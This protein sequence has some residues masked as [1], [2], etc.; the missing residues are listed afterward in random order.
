MD[1]TEAKYDYLLPFFWELGNGKFTGDADKQLLAPIQI[2]PDLRHAAAL[3]WR[4]VFDVFSPEVVLAA[5]FRMME[6]WINS[7]LEISE[8]SDPSPNKMSVKRKLMCDYIDEFASFTGKINLTEICG[9]YLEAW[10]NVTKG[11]A[12]IANL[13]SISEYMTQSVPP[14]PLQW[15]MPIV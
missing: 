12:P 10:N 7:L 15:Y 5:V 1:T 8:D 13:S 2:K 4:F 11:Q 6:L 14:L 3:S 9:Q